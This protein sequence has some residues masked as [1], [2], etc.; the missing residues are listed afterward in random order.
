MAKKSC[1]K[2]SKYAFKKTGIPLYELGSGGKK[3]GRKAGRKSKKRS[4]TIS[5]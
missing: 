1:Y 4:M 3:R 2:R 5:A